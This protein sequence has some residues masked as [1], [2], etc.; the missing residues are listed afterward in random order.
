QAK[1]GIR[2]ERYLVGSEMCIRDSLYGLYFISAG[3]A[4]IIFSLE[5]VFILVLSVLICSVKI[6]SP[7]YFI[8]FLIGAIVGLSLIHISEP[9]S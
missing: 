2:A 3:S 9:T 5:S 1:D 7:Q 6:N 8:L 4:S